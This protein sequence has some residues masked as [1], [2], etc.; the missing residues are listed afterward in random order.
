MTTRNQL[1]PHVSDDVLHQAV[2]V[3]K[4][5][6]LQLQCGSS[7]VFRL[8]TQIFRSWTGIENSLCEYP[9]GVFYGSVGK[10]RNTIQLHNSKQ[11]VFLLDLHRIMD[12]L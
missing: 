4:H 5:T 8:A 11:N 1:V 10:P 2:S 6:L 7:A 12:N 9:V 3:C